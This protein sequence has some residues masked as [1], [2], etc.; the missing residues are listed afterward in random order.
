MFPL[1]PTKSPQDSEEETD[2]PISTPVDPPEDVTPAPVVVAPPPEEECLTSFNLCYALDMSGSVCN[3]GKP[4]NCGNCSPYDD[5]RDTDPNDS[6]VWLFEPEICCNNFNDINMFAADMTSRLYDLTVGAA[7]NVVADAAT[8]GT[9]V[10]TF[11]TSANVHGVLSTNVNDTLGSLET[12]SYSGGYTDHKDAIMKCQSTLPPTNID[13]SDSSSGSSS[14]QNFI[15]LV[16]DGIPT[17]PSGDSETYAISAANSAKEEGTIIL[18]VFINSA[19]DNLDQ[20]D[21]MKQLSYDGSSIWDISSFDSLNTIMES[22]TSRVLCGNAGDIKAMDDYPYIATP[23]EE[24]LIHVIV[25]D[26]HDGTAQIVNVTQPEF[27]SVT[28]DLNGVNVPEGKVKYVSPSNYIGQETFTY[29]ICNGGSHVDRHSRR[30]L[31]SCDTATV[32]IDVIHPDPAANDD[33]A[34]TSMNTPIIVNLLEND[35][36]ST[37]DLPLS[38]SSVGIP[39]HGTVYLGGTIPAGH[40][41]YYPT[42][43]YVG[44]D[45][46]RYTACDT[47]GSC[48]DAQVT[49]EV[50]PPPITALNDYA[51]TPHEQPVVV[52][53]L[54]NDMGNDI[55]VDSIVSS[56]QNGVVSIQY[57][58]DGHGVSVLYQPFADF[59]GLDT[60]TYQACEKD[61]TEN[62]SIAT[63]TVDVILAVDDMSGTPYETPLDIQVVQNDH[64]QDLVVSNVTIPSNGNVSISIEDDKNVIYVPNAGFVG[65]D[66]FT[67]T[68]CERDSDGTVCDVATVTIDVILCRDDVE[69]TLMDT[70]ISVSLIDNDHG[71]DLVIEEFPTQPAYGDV[72]VDHEL[73]KSVLYTPNPGL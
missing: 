34:T 53:V 33:T 38:M 21:Y 32:T 73:G 22:V 68:A 61:D 17:R 72:V 9:S 59:V 64:G 70:P 60:F 48:V 7:E 50:T 67:Y 4:L 27:G 14:V 10:V 63:V 1:E 43:N 25:N 65:L 42:S 66:S 26:V 58:N 28:F 8:M 20:L 46:F 57:D 71:V 54:S 18:P 44:I 51:G 24:L 69:T 11:A 3:N 47:T 2:S 16:T 15:I 37:S 31:T 39:N 29:T 55:E 19:T 13:D 56:P 23:N 35:T 52:N 12:L 6:S 40:I 41:K 5:C 36:P 45:T 62:C 30:R 49:V